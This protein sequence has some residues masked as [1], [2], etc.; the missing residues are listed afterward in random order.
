M[1]RSIA[2][3]VAFVALT[4]TFVVLPVYAAPT[5]EAHPVEVSVEEVALGSVDRAS[6]GRPW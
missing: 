3:L 4:G 2:G 6:R 1:R 5:P